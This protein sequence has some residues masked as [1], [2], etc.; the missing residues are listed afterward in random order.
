MANFMTLGTSFIYGN[1]PGIVAER[2]WSNVRIFG[3][4]IFDAFDYISANI[5]FITTSL[6]SAIFIGFVLKRDI[7]LKELTNGG[8]INQKIAPIL[9]YH[10]KFVIP[11]LI[12][13]IFAFSFA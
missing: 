6:L 13:L 9:F 7:A 10:I 3:M 11:A 5:L 2:S 1:I 12:L 4:N 8:T